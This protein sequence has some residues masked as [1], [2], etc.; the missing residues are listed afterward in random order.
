[1]LERRVDKNIE[2]YRIRV[3]LG[4]FARQPRLLDFMVN[5]SGD[6]VVV[7]Q[8]DG[9]TVAVTVE[10]AFS[11]HKTFKTLVDKKFPVVCDKMW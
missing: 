8:P 11:K 4:M 7:L 2:Q 10:T 6:D 5:A 3:R 1:M 9:V